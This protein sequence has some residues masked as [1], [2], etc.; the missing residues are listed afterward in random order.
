MKIPPYPLTCASM[1]SFICKFAHTRRSKH[2]V[3]MTVLLSTPHLS[4]LELMP[5]ILSA[6]TLWFLL[7]SPFP[8]LPGQDGGAVICMRLCGLWW[9]TGGPL[10]NAPPPPAST[11]A[12]S[13]LKHISR[14]EQQPERSVRS[15]CVIYNRLYILIHIIEANAVYSLAADQYKEITACHD[16]GFYEGNYIDGRMS[17]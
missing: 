14:S 13:Q 2:R 12:E 10:V 15:L 1:G 9:R 3:E 4:A 11:L 17:D 6:K 5:L 8:L 16:A 7:P